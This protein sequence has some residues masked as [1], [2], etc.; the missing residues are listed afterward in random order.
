[1]VYASNATLNVMDALILAP[2]VSIALQDITNVDLFVL[3]LAILTNILMKPARLASPAMLNAKHAQANNSAPLVPTLKQFQSMVSVTIV[4][5]LATHAD[6]LHPFA[7]AVSVDSTL[8][9]Q[10]ALLLVPKEP[11]QSMES[12]NAQMDSFTPTNVLL[13][14]QLDMEQS[15]DNV[16]NALLTALH[17]QD[18]YQHAQAASMDTHLT[19]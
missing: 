5:I 10:P 18:L 3:R 19:S 16:L 17:A 1:M 4:H 11:P 6:Q 15:V 14:A 13:P 12:A 9:D 8:S 2:T 7:Q